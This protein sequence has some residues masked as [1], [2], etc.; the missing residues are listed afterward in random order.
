VPDTSA[1]SR[2]KGRRPDRGRPTESP[3][4]RPV[5]ARGDFLES[6]LSA[7]PWKVALALAALHLV[8]AFFTFNPTPHV[9]GDNAAYVSLAKS[10]VERHAYLELWDP[11]AHPHTQYPPVW[12][13]IIAF[14]SLL[15]LK[16]WVVLKSAVT[17]FSVLCIALSYLWLRRTSTR[18]IALIA[19]F[20]L[21]VA[22]GVLEQAHWELSDVPAWAFTML[23]LWASTHLV[24]AP[25]TEG[26]AGR[27]AHHGR[28]LAVL[29]VGVILGNFTRS[30]GLPLVVAA[31]AWFAWRRQWRDLGILLAAFLPPAFAW[32]LRGRVYG[33]PGYLSHLWA[34]DPYQPRLG[35][36]GPMDMVRRIG[37][38]LVRYEGMHFPILLTWEGEH[39]YLLGGAVMVLAAA[40]W[41]RRMARPALAEFWVPIYVALLLVWPATWS[42]E[43]FV[44]PI[45]P[46]ILCYAAEA[47]RDFTAVLGR[48]RAAALAPA[49]GAV[50][51]LAFAGPGLAKEVKV[52][53]F[54][55]RAYASGDRFRCMS[56]E[57]HDFFTVAEMTNGML[58][59]GSAVLSRKPTIFYVLSGYPSRV[60]PLS[61]RPDSFFMGAREAR[62]DFVVF[63]RIRDLA[64]LYLHPVLLAARDQFCVVQGLS[65]P[66]AGILRIT[67]GAP[68]RVGVAENSFRLCNAQGQFLTQAPPA[69]ARPAPPPT[70]APPPPPPP[71]VR[72]P[73]FTQPR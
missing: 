48:P 24:G 50:I 56:E 69:P 14:L 34:V 19:G 32:W 63:D 43:R 47:V 12:P 31:A 51:L 38:N 44:L 10:L 62:A 1:R 60:Y 40:G 8:L 25:E 13:A 23:A 22:P 46:L 15:G 30:A 2:S 5:R 49:V 57:Y 64:P 71:A 11:A 21:A 17:A 61:A 58:P 72:S 41:G 33:A 66:N 68:R 37:S 67:P 45:L 65:L 7:A 39:R 27:E 4:P 53:R 73:I 54:C 42:G 3:A 6:V 59:D 55:S 36:I 70:L 18:E 29:V 35:T 9:G 52:G 16:G 20:V 28:W 26:E